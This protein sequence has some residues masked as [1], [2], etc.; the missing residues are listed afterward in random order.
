L[1]RAF[2]VRTDRL[3]RANEIVT[4]HTLEL[5]STD[6]SRPYGWAIPLMSLSKAGKYLEPTFDRL[7]QIAGMEHNRLLVKNAAHPLVHNDS[8]GVRT[9]VLD[10]DGDLDGAH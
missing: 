9:A 8:G 10:G 4:G 1:H 5:Q 7:E 2:K 6:F 3:A